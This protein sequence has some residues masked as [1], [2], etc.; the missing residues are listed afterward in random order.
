MKSKFKLAIISNIDDHLFV[1]SKEHL[2]IEFDWIITSEQA[3][4][5]KPSLNNFRFAIEKIGVP[6]ENILHIAQSMYHDIIPAKAIGLSTAWVN[7]RKGKEG[8]GATPATHSN[9]EL[10]VPDLKTLVSI[11]GQD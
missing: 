2:K 11:I 5:Y 8:T 6:I 3:R 1:Y 7:R 4:S 9:T 10:E